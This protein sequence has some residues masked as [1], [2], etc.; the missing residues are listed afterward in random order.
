MDEPAVTIEVEGRTVTAGPSSSIIEAIWAAGYTLVTN[1]G[2]LGQ[3]VC[4]SCR[5]M[6]SRSGSP[7]VKMA[8]ACETLIEPG[9]RVAFVAHLTPSRARHLDV[10]RVRDS[11]ELAG[12]LHASF[13]EAAHCR[14]CGGC[15]A[16]CPRE[17]DVHG[18]VG[19]AVDGRLGTAGEQFDE[20]VMCG[21]CTE[22]CPESIDPN[23]LGL[24]A[25][26][27]TTSSFVRPANLLH[28]LQELERG[29]H[30]VER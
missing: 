20:C 27:V 14:H 3:G 28:R 13:P 23:H 11:W 8:L 17:I 22:A 19:L 1:V 6:V 2:C 4:G 16:A 26:R 21:L 30:T 12:E 25:R 29:E 5:V 10:D 18:G 15:N 9:M 24:W 7:W